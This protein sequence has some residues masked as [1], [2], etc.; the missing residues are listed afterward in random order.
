MGSSFAGL[1]EI[2]RLKNMALY[3]I[4]N[5]EL[6][7]L[8]TT[9]FHEENLW[10]RRDLQALLKANVEAIDPNVMVIAEEFGDWDQSGDVV[11]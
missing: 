1:V 3:Q 6:Y 11:Q 8:E 2:I 4:K 10:E 5:N 7:P 9:R